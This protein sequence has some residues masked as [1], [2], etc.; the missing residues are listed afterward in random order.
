MLKYD[1]Y[2]TLSIYEANQNY[3]Q[4]TSQG[5]RHCSN[6][7]LNFKRK[8]MTEFGESQPGT[9]RGYFRMCYLIHFLGILSFSLFPSL[10]KFENTGSLKYQH[11]TD[12]TTSY[13]ILLISNLVVSNSSSE[14]RTGSGLS[15]DSGMCSSIH[16][17]GSS[18]SGVA[19][20]LGDPF[21][22]L[23]VPEFLILTLS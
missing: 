19:R 15:A 22:V 16:F 4:K 17:N 6:E 11:K 20:S 23:P 3:A 18:S 2:G 13:C 10:L 5:C 7:K 14:S 21:G 1:K 12:Q 8:L 9:Q